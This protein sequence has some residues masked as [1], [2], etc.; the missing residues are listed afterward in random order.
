MKKII[1]YQLL[2][3]AALFVIWSQ[4]PLG[5]I[6]TWLADQQLAIN[7]MITSALAG[8]LYCLR[9][10]YV[11]YSANNNWEPLWEVWY[12][13]RPIAS[14]LTG[15]VAYIFL[16]ASIVVLEASQAEDAGNFGYLAFSFIGGYNV[17]RFLKK[18][19]DLAKSTFG[20]EKS[21]SYERENNDDGT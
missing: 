12:Y 6:P 4:D 19:E 18:I 14:A 10:I 11:N 9:A 3:I 7:C 20:V 17:D 5:N 1:A 2:L 13:L 16:K 15:L 8:V 21:R